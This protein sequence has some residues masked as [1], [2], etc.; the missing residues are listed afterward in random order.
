MQRVL[1]QS[2]HGAET[3]LAKINQQLKVTNNNS[4]QTAEG[5]QEMAKEL[6]VITGIDGDQIL[7]DITS[8]LLKF[9]NIQ[10]QVFQD[11]QKQLLTFQLF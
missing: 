3:A 9:G 1:L 11:A 5:L 10:G 7:N 4:G 8:G 6:E 2:L